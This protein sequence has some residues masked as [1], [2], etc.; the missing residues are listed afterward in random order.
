METLTPALYLGN[1]V[2]WDGDR[3]IVTDDELLGRVNRPYL[4]ASTSKAMHSCPSRMVADRAMPSGFDLFGAPELGTAAH[5]IL[6][7]L[8]TLPP[9][10]RDRQHAMAILTELAREVPQ[11]DDDVDYA[12]KIGQDP[13]RHTMWVALVA[14]AFGGIF[15]IEDP[16]DVVVHSNELRLDGIEVAGVPF[17]GFVDR[18]DTLPD[19]RLRII[20]YKGL[21]L[22][23]P[24]PT[25]TGWTTM[26][27]LSVG[28]EVLGAAGT[29]VAVTGK[30]QVHNR[31]CYQ[32][33]FSDGSTVIC[34]NVHL[35]QVEDGTPGGVTVN[36]DDLH[37]KLTGGDQVRLVPGPAG[38]VSV[39]ESVTVPSV[40]TQCIEVDAADSLYLCGPLMVPTHNSGKDKSKV[41]KF[42]DDDHGDQIRLYIEAATVVFGEKPSAGHL[43]YITHGK[44]RRVAIGN[45]DVNKAKRGFVAS[46]EALQKAAASRQFATKQSPLC[47]WCP[48][49]NSC[50]TAA[51]NGMTDRKG[52][53]PTAVDLGIPN[54]RPDSTF[55]PIVAGRSKWADVA[56]APG[57]AHM[58][59]EEEPPHDP[60]IEGSTMSG[61]TDK[62]W[63]E[64]K[65]YDGGV[66]DGHLSL[67]SYA[68]T[69]VFG[70]SSLAAEQLS[71]AGRKV[72]PG[73]VKAVAALLASTV[74]NAQAAVTNG[75]RDWQ[76]GSNT[77]LR[78]LLRTSL[79]I[80]P[81]PFGGDVGAWETWSKRTH[82]FMVAVSATALDIFDNGPVLDLGALV[83]IEAAPAPVAVQ[84]VPA[85]A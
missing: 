25:P 44:Q 77:R 70:L 10:R 19:G 48:L 71:K 24:I 27:D 41:N 15:D 12:K 63:R 38:T 2:A 33:T 50:P 8:Y 11:T 61:T 28:D 74:L 17:K 18:V 66:V 43:Y 79:D 82:G 64:A 32:L 47:G 9:G 31:P 67:N 69:A 14:K 40:P 35:W 72:G 78:G 84:A 23:T 62:K 56:Q 59:C 81:L 4:S 85:A 80:I 58:P 30:S 73:P 3:L 20:D 34:D 1:R 5:T 68:S 53:A 29:G 36:A 7:R 46:W 16:R 75:S 76:E 21:A 57:A 42:Y 65:P 83:G 39:L 22:D 6:E 54:L 60:E 26:G 51:A 37:A 45:T 52:G 49:V 13:V 55:T